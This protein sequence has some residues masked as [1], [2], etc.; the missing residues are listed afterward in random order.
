MIEPAVTCPNCATEIKLTE[1]LAAPLI[2]ATR[3]DF[4][5]RISGIPAEV[6]KKEEELTKQRD[7]LAEAEQSFEQRVAAKLDTE[8]HKIA[9]VAPNL[10]P[11]PAALAPPD[12]QIAM[13]SSFRL[14]EDR[15]AR[16]KSP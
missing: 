12:R 2:E 6:A 13:P 14:L 11:T 7:S 3:R 4:E 8:R 16:L 9:A 1:S 5:K 15:R 10:I